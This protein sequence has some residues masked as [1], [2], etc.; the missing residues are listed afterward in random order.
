VASGKI[1]WQLGELLAYSSLL[2]EGRDIRMSGPGRKT[3]HIQ[4]PP[5]LCN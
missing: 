4:P 2:L 1:D 5:R 3:R